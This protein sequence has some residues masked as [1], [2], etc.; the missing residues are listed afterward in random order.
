MKIYLCNTWLG[1]VASHDTAFRDAAQKLS[2][3]GYT[4]ITS[5]YLESDIQ[6]TWVWILEH[7]LL[8]MLPCKKVV[9][10]DGWEKSLSAR[11]EVIVATTLKKPVLTYPDM[12]PI[13]NATNFSIEYLPQPQP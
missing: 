10:L 3:M 2:I 8:Q 9:V 13:R 12:K 1:I 11:L 7:D 4:V 5:T 6:H